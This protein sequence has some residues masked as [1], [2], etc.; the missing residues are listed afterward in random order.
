MFVRQ[1]TN[2]TSSKLSELDGSSAPF[3]IAL[4]SSITSR[5][6]SNF[7]F[8]KEHSIH[9]LFSSVHSFIYWKK[10][11]LFSSYSVYDAVPNNSTYITIHI[12]F[13]LSRIMLSVLS[14][15]RVLSDCTFWF[16]KMFT[17][18]S[19]PVSTNFVIDQSSNLT[20]IL[21]HFSCNV[22]V[23]LTHTVPCIPIYCSCVSKEH[24]GITSY[25]VRSVSFLS[26]SLVF[27]FYVISFLHG[28]FFYIAWF[29]VVI[30]HIN[31]RFSGLP[32]TT[33]L[34]CIR[35]QT[36]TYIS[37]F[38]TIY[39]FHFPLLIWWLFKTHFCKVKSFPCTSLKIDSF[40]SSKTFTEVSIL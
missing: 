8:C 14:L 15:G 27:V 30:F 3:V 39:S 32:A 4:Q 36:A 28:I 17:F 34:T 26:Q 11:H 13:S 20:L 6:I 35:Y 25:N 2:C 24:S 5:T 1:R 16:H 33:I 21:F 19:F 22:T 31:F 37:N 7:S 40:N 38:S 18:P 29:S 10:L 23:Y 12:P 9:E